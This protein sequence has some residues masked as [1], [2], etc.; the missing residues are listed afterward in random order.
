MKKPKFNIAHIFLTLLIFSLP[1]RF[2]ISADLPQMKEGKGLVVFYRESSFKG[3]AI[4]FNLNQGQEPIGSLPSG[5]TLYRYVEPGQHTFWSQVISKDSIT[6]D[7]VAGETY[8][9]KGVTQMGLL[10]GRPK[11]VLATESK[12]KSAIA[13]IKAKN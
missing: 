13:K 12:A 3:G 8:Y 11:L 1:M 2:A 4:R 5:T 6:I 10:A 7:V 9:I